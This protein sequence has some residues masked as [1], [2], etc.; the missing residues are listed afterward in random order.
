ME[1]SDNE[2]LF[3][4]SH[5]GEQRKIAVVLFSSL[6]ISEISQIGSGLSGL[7]TAYLLSQRTT[8][9]VHIFE[10]EDKIGVDAASVTVTVFK[11]EKRLEANVDVPMRSIDSGPFP[12][13]CYQ[14]WP[15]ISGYYPRLLRL[16]KRLGVDVRPNDLTFAFSKEN[17]RLPY[18][19]YNGVSGLRGISIPSSNSFFGTFLDIFYY[20]IGFLYL[21]IISLLHYHL[22]FFPSIKQITFEQFCDNYLIPRKFSREVLV[23]LYSGVCTCKESDILRYPANLIV[24]MFVRHEYINI[25]ANIH[26]LYC[27]RIRNKTLCYSFSTRI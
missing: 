7:T 1:G 12:K 5:N 26:R 6:S 27:R 24:G 10:K 22:H 15:L 2:E 19:I 20:S 23:P 18:L 4:R 8:Y 21:C 25:N 14:D 13:F 9:E 3:R 16:L 17:T 11:D